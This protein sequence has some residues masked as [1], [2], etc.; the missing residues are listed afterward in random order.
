MALLVGAG[1][2]TVRRWRRRARAGEALS[3]RR[4]PPPSVPDRDN[5]KVRVAEML[6][7]ELRGLAGADALSKAVPGLSRRHAAIVKSW[8]LTAMERERKAE[9]DRVAVT[10]PGVM[11]GFDAMDVATTDRKRYPLCSSDAAIPYTTSI[12]VEERYDTLAVAGA[13]DA[14]FGQHGAPLVLRNDR[15]RAHDAPQVRDVCQRHQVLVLHGPP[16]HPGYYGQLER[17]NLDRRTWLD[18]LGLVA[19]DE[20][21]SA[22]ERMRV[23]LNSLWPRR[24][25]AWHT[26]EEMWKG[27]P[28]ITIDRS[29]LA[30]EVRDL[31]VRLD[32]TV[33]APAYPGFTERLAIE[34]ALTRHGLLHRVEGGGC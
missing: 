13:L 33:V 23:C 12:A 21:V 24:S 28:A 2:S 6:V 22:C 19:P 14:D 11:R 15:W 30:A 7:R 25:L 27:R 4:G 3:R 29:E 8:T 32:Q 1:A 9:Q 10:T 17:Q 34:A 31:Q 26:P 5:P 16:H 20:L 18:H